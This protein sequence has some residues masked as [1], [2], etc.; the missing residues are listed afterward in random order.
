M[1]D[2]QQTPVADADAPSV[3]TPE[4]LSYGRYLKVNELIS[5]QRTLAEP[6]AHD[7]LLFIIVHQSYELW[8]KQVL[9]E[10]EHARDALFANEIADALHWLARVETIERLLVGQ[11]DVIESM[12]FQDFLE[13]RDVLKPASGF[14][15]IQFREIEALSGLKEERHLEMAD[16]DEERAR[17]Q[18]RLDEPTLWDAF[19][20]AMERTGFAMPRDDVDARHKS[21]QRFMRER[22]EHPLLHSVAEALVSHDSLTS[23]W[24]WRHVLMVERQIGAKI[25]TGGS[26]G[27]AYLR[28]TMEKRFYPDLWDMRS[29]YLQA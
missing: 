15:S 26:A 2:V 10:L 25:G 9:F 13:F 20:A 1:P 3:G 29:D 18:R 4:G 8:F 19:C 16:T 27:A 22:R 6:A 7:E 21:L 11:V 17:L 23:M 28:S 12:L 5:L 14:Q 24:R